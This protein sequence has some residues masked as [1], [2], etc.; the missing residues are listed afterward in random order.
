MAGQPGANTH[1][2][3]SGAPCSTGGLRETLDH[4]VKGWPPPPTRHSSPAT[5]PGNTSRS[6]LTW[7]A[8][9]EDRIEPV[10]KIVPPCPS[11]SVAPCNKVL[12]GE[13]CPRMVYPVRTFRTHPFC[14]RP[15]GVCLYKS[16]L[17]GSS[18]PGTPDQQISSSRPFCLPG[19]LWGCGLAPCRPH[20]W[21]TLRAA[22][23]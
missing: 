17:Q 5:N 8:H 6:K 18:S 4:V 14:S 7:S 13:G 15:L 9:T 10:G 12:L 19:F 1:S 22:S 2:G 21:N 3:F 20:F 16:C 23:S 11:A